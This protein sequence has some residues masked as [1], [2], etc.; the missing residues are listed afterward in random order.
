MEGE[1][2][3]SADEV[4]GTALLHLDA[5]KFPEVARMFDAPPEVDQP[6]F[7]EKETVWVCF[8]EAD[9]IGRLAGA[10]FHNLR[11]RAKASRRG[12]YFLADE[13]GSI[14]SLQG[15]EECF[16]MGRGYRTFVLIALQD[17]SQL[18]EKHGRHAVYSILG[19]APLKVFGAS[20]DPETREYFSNL[21]GTVQV[22]RRIYEDDGATRAWKQLFWRGGAPFAV[23]EESRRGVL[24]EHLQALPKGSWFLYAGD[25]REIRLV[26]APPF[27]S[28]KTRVLPEARRDAVVLGVPRRRPEESEDGGDASEERARQEAGTPRTC[29][30]CGHEPASG[31][32]A[33]CEACGGR[34]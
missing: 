27:S 24:G 13:A 16:Q 34:L 12:A 6:R 7:L 23:R 21:T 17:L 5:L 8:P 28:W 10:L 4:V 1:H 31:G 26:T 2:K 20:D 33:F 11:A 30:G 29:P 32:A 14:L 18:I 3:K 9:L 15:I 22:R 19:N 25:P